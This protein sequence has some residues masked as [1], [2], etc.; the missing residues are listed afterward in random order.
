M[1]TS[2]LPSTETPPVH[3]DPPTF[4]DGDAMLI[5]GLNG[6]YSI[7]TMNE[8]PTLWQRFAPHIGNIPGQVDRAAYGVCFLS[9]NGVDYLS[10]VQVSNS[11]GLPS[12]FQ[13]VSIPAQR[14]AVFAHQGHVSTLCETCDAIERL[15]LPRSHFHQPKNSPNFFERYG[16]GF[17]PQTGIGDIEVWVPI[18]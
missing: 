5:A 17:N 3:L 14:Y 16:E 11:N 4:K 9:S 8:I 15:W 12:G 2:Q 10:G 6:H 18:G 7:D 1:T 13:V